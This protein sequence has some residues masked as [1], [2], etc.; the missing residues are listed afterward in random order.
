MFTAEASWIRSADALSLQT[1]QFRGLKTIVGKI[2]V[3]GTP[4]VAVACQ[5]R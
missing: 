2:E 5:P 3:D 4:I 1:A